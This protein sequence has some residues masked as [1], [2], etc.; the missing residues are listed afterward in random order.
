MEEVLISFY[1]TVMSH[2]LLN[3]VY[4]KLLH[5]ETKDELN[6]DGYGG[7]LIHW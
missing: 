7:L 1:Y 5:M 6:E 4:L 2:M 3:K